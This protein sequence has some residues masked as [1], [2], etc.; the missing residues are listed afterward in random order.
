MGI[1]DQVTAEQWKLIYNAP[2]AAATYVATASG[3]VLELIKELFAVGKMV[4]D[5]AR[6]S[7]GSG[8]GALVDAVL[9]EMQAMSKG[10]AQS[11]TISYAGRDAEGMRAEARRIVADAAGVLD[12]VPGGDGYKTW[13]GAVARKA[14][15]ASRDGFLGLGGSG[16]PVDDEEQAA[17]RDLAIALGISA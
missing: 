11:A 13:L 3:G 2:F 9:E 17:L 1:K 6:Q 8:Y 16:R 4:T 12:T 15:E 5:Q 14:A 10:D 7:G